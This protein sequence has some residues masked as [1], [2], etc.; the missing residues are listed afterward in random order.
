MTINDYDIVADLYDTYVPVAY[1]VNFFVSE[2]LKTTGEVLELMS[3]TGRVSI[4]LMEA[5]VILTC[6]DNSA[7]SNAILQNKLEDKGLKAGVYTMDICEFDLHKQFSMVIIPF[8]SFAH[9]VSPESQRLAL[10]RIYQHL[11]PGG[12][13]I[14]TLGNPIV[15]AKDVDGQLRLAYTYP[16]PGGGKLLL[17]ILEQ[18]DPQD[19][20]V[21]QAFEFFE[22]YDEAGILHSKRLMELHF[23][24]TAKEQFESLLHDAGFSIQALYGDYD[25]HKFDDQSSSSL[26]WVLTKI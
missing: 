13:F 20:Q 18:F 24:L 14:C 25:Y 5:G 21:V 11:L 8:A 6:V 26:I 12:T 16:L 10:H 2:A 19:E 9:I 22:Q 15:R 3:G 17:W 23:R 1:D 4:P 7:R